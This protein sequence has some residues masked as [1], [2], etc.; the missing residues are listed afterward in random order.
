M[1]QQT[2][3]TPSI[4]QAE[5]ANWCKAYLAQI[6]DRAESEIELTTSFTR[7]GLDSSV[8]VGM[9]GNLGDWLGCKVDP[10]AAFDYPTIERLSRALAADGQILAAVQ[11]ARAVRT[12]Q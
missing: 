2:I 4:L 8:I 5:I 6:L 7:Y 12:A 9:T 10:A 11:Q 3:L 1:T